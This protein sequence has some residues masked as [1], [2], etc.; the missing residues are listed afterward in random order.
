MTQGA[1]GGL[2]PPGRAE[3]GPM[4]RTDWVGARAQARTSLHKTSKTSS[5]SEAATGLTKGPNLLYLYP[6]LVRAPP[7]AIAEPRHGPGARV[8]L[9]WPCHGTRANE[10]VMSAGDADYHDDRALKSGSK[11]WEP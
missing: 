8:P 2:D 5:G 10:A 6:R 9:P 3:N 7:P 1:Q 11:G 4:A